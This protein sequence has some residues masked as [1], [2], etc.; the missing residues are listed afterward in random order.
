MANGLSVWI[1]RLL[2]LMG[3]HDYRLIE[4]IEAFGPA[5]NVEKVQ[6]RRCGCVTIRG[7]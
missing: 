3:T 4:V 2:C 7:G 6:C 5:G 1:G